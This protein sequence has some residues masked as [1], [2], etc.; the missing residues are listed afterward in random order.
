MIEKLNSSNNLK[1]LILH[2]VDHVV[3]TLN[4]LQQL[5]SVDRF[6][7]NFIASCCSHIKPDKDNLDKITMYTFAVEKLGRVFQE[8]CVTKNINPRVF[9][10]V[11]EGINQLSNHDVKEYFKWIVEM[12]SIMIHWHEKFFDEDFNY[13]DIFMYVSNL[14]NISK[15]AAGL[16]AGYLVYKS[17]EMAKIKEK[18]SSLFS[19]LCLLIVKSIK[20][21]GW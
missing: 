17:D 20:D 2:S 19:D 18:Y 13:D 7:W 3:K 12:Q 6:Y 5:S 4:Y 15:F 1:A 21:T 14:N 8:Y 16:N 9:F 10:T 11:P